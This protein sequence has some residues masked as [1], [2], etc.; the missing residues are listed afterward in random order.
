M[1]K[2]TTRGV[3]KDAAA[4]APKAPDAATDANSSRRQEQAAAS[5]NTEPLWLNCPICRQPKFSRLIKKPT[6]NSPKEYDVFSCDDC[7]AA[8]ALVDNKKG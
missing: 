5:E 4:N 6:K 1:A 7:Y 2:H 8:F 3:I